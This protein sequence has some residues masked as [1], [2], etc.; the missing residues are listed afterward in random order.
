[1][2]WSRSGIC[3]ETD[4]AKARETGD[5]SPGQAHVLESRPRTARAAIPRDDTAVRRTSVS[6][7]DLEVAERA[8]LAR[9]VSASQD[10]LAAELGASKT[11]VG[12]LCKQREIE[13]EASEARGMM[14]PAPVRAIMFRAAKD[15][16]DFERSRVQPYYQTELE[17]KNRLLREAVFERDNLR[18]KLE[19]AAT[20]S[21]NSDA[22]VDKLN[23]ELGNALLR[24]AST[25]NFLDRLLQDAGKLRDRV[26]ELEKQLAGRAAVETT[27][28]DDNT[29]IKPNL[30]V[31]ASVKTSLQDAEKLNST[32]DKVTDLDGQFETSMPLSREDTKPSAT[33]DSD[34]CSFDPSSVSLNARGNGETQIDVEEWLSD[35]RGEP[36]Q[37][38]GMVENPRSVPPELEGDRTAPPS[39]TVSQCFVQTKDRDVANF[40]DDTPDFLRS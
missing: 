29:G 3:E 2:E 13:N 34:H 39:D 23:S 19:E 25:Q 11:T 6:L 7:A 16:M 18:E 30:A 32:R 9:G 40:D 33:P 22:I 38:D 15:I 27:H 12:R 17:D 8:L 1:M 37:N 5:A 35:H 36:A 21:V 4:T 20:N 14:L 10:R 24:I 26:S 28:S 31:I